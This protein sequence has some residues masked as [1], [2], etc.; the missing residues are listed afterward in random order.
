V[1]EGGSVVCW[2]GWGKGRGGLSLG[3]EVA[4]WV[5]CALWRGAAGRFCVCCML[6]APC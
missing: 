4:R 1:P 2:V 6:A 5:G 3:G